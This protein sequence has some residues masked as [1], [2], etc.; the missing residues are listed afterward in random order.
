MSGGKCRGENVGWANVLGGGWQMSGYI[1]IEC[2]GDIHVLYGCS[3]CGGKSR[4]A[5]LSPLEKKLTVWCMGTF[6]TYEGRAFLYIEGPFLLMATFRRDKLG[7]IQEGLQRG[8]QDFTRGGGVAVTFNKMYAIK[9]NHLL[10]RV[11]TL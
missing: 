2:L 5:S 6:S 4:R 3:Q 7:K 9:L 8:G 10:F 11:S 1:P